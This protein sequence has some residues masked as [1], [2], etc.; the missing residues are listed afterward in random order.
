MIKI[1][2]KILLP[3]TPI[4]AIGSASGGIISLAFMMETINVS[5]VIGTIS[6]G[7]GMILSLAGGFTATMAL[8]C[9]GEDGGSFKLFL[10]KKEKEENDILQN[11]ALAETAQL[12]KELMDTG[13]FD[14]KDYTF[15]EAQERLQSHPEIIS[16]VK[17]YI[18]KYNKIEQNKKSIEET[19]NQLIQNGG[20]SKEEAN[21]PFGMED[22]KLRHEYLEYLIKKHPTGTYKYSGTPMS[23]QDLIDHPEKLIK[24][25]NDDKNNDTK[26]QHKNSPV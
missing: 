5:N 22:K 8:F 4:L 9:L 2:H 17:E 12:T 18:A 21:I 15:E 7:A 16:T 19:K 3:L 13:Y 26:N 6:Y 24:I 23:L 11:I 20:W 25:D 1:P 14:G 10:N